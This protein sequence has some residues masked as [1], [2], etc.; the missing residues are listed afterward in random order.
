MDRGSENG[1]ESDRFTE[2]RRLP[3]KWTPTQPRNPR[4][5]SEFDGSLVHGRTA[6][7]GGAAKGCDHARVADADPVA[8]RDNFRDNQN[9]IG[10]PVTCTL[11]YT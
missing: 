7:F 10:S 5:F 9:E 8:D 2:R 3:Q 6:T 4:V 11:A 1:G